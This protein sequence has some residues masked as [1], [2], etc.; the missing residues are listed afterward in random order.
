MF[1]Q[2]TS[3]IRVLRDSEVCLCFRFFLQLHRI[4]SGFQKNPSKIE[5][6][7]TNGPYQVSCDRAIRYSGFFRVC[8]FVGPV[9][10]FFLDS[11]N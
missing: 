5:S 11:C 2:N 7:L 10:R 3:E 1:I 6:D 8:S 4:L 9:W